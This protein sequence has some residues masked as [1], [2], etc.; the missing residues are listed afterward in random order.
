MLGVW[1]LMPTFTVL[2]TPAAIGAV[3]PGVRYRDVH[4]RASHVLAAGLVE[5]GILRG[6]IAEHHQLSQTALDAQ[7]V[8]RLV[9]HDV[10]PRRLADRD[11]PDGGAAT[12]L[13]SEAYAKSHGLKPLGRLVAWAVAGVEPT[14]TP[15]TAIPSLRSRS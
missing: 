4:L 1:M 10:H 5:L 9:R 7:H 2:K 6:L 12:V 13:A 11:E 14:L 8:P 3:A 15:R